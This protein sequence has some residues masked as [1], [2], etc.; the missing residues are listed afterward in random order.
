MR[1]TAKEAVQRNH[2]PGALPSVPAGRQ[3]L[4][5]TT[6]PYFKR[7]EKRS[8]RCR[9]CHVGPLSR[10][11]VWPAPL[12][13][14]APRLRPHWLTSPSTALSIPR[15]CRPPTLKSRPLSLSRSPSSLPSIPTTSLSSVPAPA[16]SP[17]PFRPLRKVQRPAACKRGARRFHRA[18][19]PPASCSTKATSR[20]S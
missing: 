3:H 6:R 12:L 4:R 5:R 7:F 14:Q 11:P 13:P 1:R 10:V 17:Q 16:V 8:M 2:L 15:V 20:A 18:A 19:L 9:T